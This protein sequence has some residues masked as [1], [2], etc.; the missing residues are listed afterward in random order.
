MVSDLTVTKALYNFGGLFAV[1]IS[2]NFYDVASLN[3]AVEG[4][5]K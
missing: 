3:I 1:K 5:R 4:R 2:K